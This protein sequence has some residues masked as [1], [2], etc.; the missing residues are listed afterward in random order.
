M[1]HCADQALPKI[2]FGTHFS[3]LSNILLNGAED[4]VEVE[5]GVVVEE[6]FATDAGLLDGA[7]VLLILR[8]WNAFLM[9]PPLEAEV[10]ARRV[11]DD[12]GEDDDDDAEAFLQLC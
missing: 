11:E 7:A 3:D 8:F 9:P 1:R 10:A 2:G 4:D 5:V 12:A 6:G